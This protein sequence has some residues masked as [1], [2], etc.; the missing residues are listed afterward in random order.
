MVEL[1][2]EAVTI[3]VAYDRTDL[4][5]D[6]TVEVTVDVR[7]NEPGVAEWALIDLGIP[8]GFT[9]VG[10]DLNALVARY[11]DVPED[12]P[13]PV[14]KRYELTGRQI[15]VYI[16]NLSNE[17]PLSFSYRLRA[18]FPIVAQTPASS[19]YDYYNPEVSGLEE[20]Q[21]I[22]VREG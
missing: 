19:A 15:L 9:V 6:D 20:P 18:K 13:D 8:P 4:R 10:E 3:D 2:P 11:T 14:I 1:A 16:G 17:Q 12:Y 21:T 7:L 22:V 5:V